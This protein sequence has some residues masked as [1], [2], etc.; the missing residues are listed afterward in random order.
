MP[1]PPGSLR[2]SRGQV[3]MYL[4]LAEGN[5]TRAAELAGVC[6]QTFQRAMRFY[7]V[8]FPRS[9]TRLDPNRVRSARELIELGIRPP[10][11]ARSMGVSVSTVRK[12]A[13]Y[14][15]WLKVR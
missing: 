14:E 4:S 2:L 5:R 3:V 1:R 13:N 15:T 12:V 11:I 8:R 7:R 10:V 9:N 6:R